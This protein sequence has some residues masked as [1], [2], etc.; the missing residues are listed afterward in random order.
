MLD[1]LKEENL[2]YSYDL[3]TF[4]S[5][6]KQVEQLQSTVEKAFVALTPEE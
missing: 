4:E 3:G 1:L 6:V 5:Y 2:A